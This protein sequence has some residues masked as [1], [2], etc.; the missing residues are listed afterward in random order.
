LTLPAFAVA[1]LLSPPAMAEDLEKVLGKQRAAEF[2]ELC[3]TSLAEMTPVFVTWSDKAAILHEAH[4]LISIAVN[5]GSLELMQLGREL[6]PATDNAANFC[7]MREKI[8]AAM[9]TSALN[10]RFAA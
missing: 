5:L 9:A 10:Q 1:I 7:A 4:N 8:L 2:A 6:S 3:R